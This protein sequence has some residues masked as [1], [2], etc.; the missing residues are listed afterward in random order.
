MNNVKTI[1]FG[2]I[3]VLI[4]IGL[5]WYSGIGRQSASVIDTDGGDQIVALDVED[6]ILGSPDAPVTI[7][8]YSSHTCGHCIDFHNDT[9]PLLV[10][11]Y[12]KT[13]QVRFILRLV[14]PLE[15]GMSV[16]CANEQSSFSEFNE[17]LF[18]N[19]GE[20]ESVDGL[21]EM[22]GTLGL[23]QDAFSQCLDSERYKD[24]ISQWFDQ[25]REDGVEGT[26]TF[27][28][29]GQ[30]LV[31]NQ[32]LEVFEQVIEEILNQEALNQ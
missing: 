2:V 15:L 21:K 4:L 14:S 27:F 12:V 19:I 9:F 32:S 22:A 1:I 28:I 16:L 5:V 30:K 26:P 23:D 17:Y 10:D 31:G 13:G 20:L 24:R 6:L 29:N 25:V 8:E 11:K 3:A 18:A 7:I